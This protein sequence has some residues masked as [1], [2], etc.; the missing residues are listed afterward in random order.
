MPISPPTPIVI[1]AS[2]AIGALLPVLAPVDTLELFLAWR[3]NAVEIAAPSLWLAESTSVIRRYVHAG[4]LTPEEG[5]GALAN[6]AALDVTVIP[7]THA[8]SRAAYAWAGRLGQARA[9]DGFYV[10]LAEELNAQFFTGDK[11]LVNAG[12]QLDVRWIHW[13]GEDI[14]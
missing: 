2:T 1:D 5:T 13:I 9:Y 3:Q 14:A 4:Q 11:R 8:R 7:D 10:A 12:R 6:L